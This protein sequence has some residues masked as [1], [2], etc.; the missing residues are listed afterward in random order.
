MLEY[1]KTS[2]GVPFLLDPQ[3]KDILNRLMGESYQTDLIELTKLTEAME[4]ADVATL[5][6]NAANKINAKIKIGPGELDV[7]Q[8]SSLQRRPIISPIQKAVVLGLKYWESVVNGATDAS[9]KKLLLSLDGLAELAK[10]NKERKGGEFKRNHLE[11]FI[12]ITQKYR[13]I[14]AYDITKQQLNNEE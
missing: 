1:T 3:N 6:F 11:E 8:L 14:G 7:A 9:I 12:K 2:G 13:L 10:L 5:A 4:Q